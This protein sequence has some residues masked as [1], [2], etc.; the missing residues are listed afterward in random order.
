M[1]AL[2][3]IP[4]DVRWRQ[5]VR[6]K[7]DHYVRFDTCDY[8]VHPKAIGRMTEV[9]ADLRTVTVT[10][11]GEIVAKHR[12]SLA[13]HRTVT[14]PEHVEARRRHHAGDIDVVPANNGDVE[15]RDLSIYDRLL[16]VAS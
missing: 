3:P 16:G 7:R 1:M 15:Q 10:L 8:S 6:I 4:I 5:A 9:A 2:P 12:R 13:S 11:Q 14:D